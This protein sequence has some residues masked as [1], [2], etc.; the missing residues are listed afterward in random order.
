MFKTRCKNASNDIVENF[1]ISGQRIN[2]IY[3]T[4]CIFFFDKT[5]TI[6]VFTE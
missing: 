1:L 5:K 3:L 6:I 4:K 2:D